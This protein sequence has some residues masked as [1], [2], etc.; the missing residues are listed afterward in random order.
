MV[1]T[2]GKTRKDT[3]LANR[4]YGI[5]KTK[6]VIAPYAMVGGVSIRSRNGAPSRKGRVLKGQMTNESK[7]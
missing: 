4:F 7:K 2:G 6:V 5:Y 3:T 1:A